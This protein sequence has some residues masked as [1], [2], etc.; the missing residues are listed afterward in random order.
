MGPVTANPD[1]GTEMTKAALTI[2]QGRIGDRN[3][4]A[5]AGSMA[6]GQAF[7]LRTGL[8]PVVIGQPEE[9]LSADW[10]VELDAA[11]PMLQELQT[12]MEAVLRMTDFSICTMPRCAAALAT[13]PMVAKHHPDVCVIWFDSHADLNTPESTISGYL[14]GLALSGPVGLWSSGLGAGIRLDRLVLVGQRDLDPFEKALIAD[15]KI[16]HLSPGPDLPQRLRAAIAG[17]CVYVHLDCDVLDPGI[18][19][20]DY[21]LDGGLSLADLQACCEVIATQ[22]VVGLEIAEFQNAWEKGGAQVS[23]EPLL[24]A[25]MPLIAKLDL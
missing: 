4:L 22:D 5:M 24:N 6:V 14:G 7:A 21:V 10:R 12:R 15:R 20:T 1:T 13:L 2:V 9:P 18:V 25:L 23:P 17:C 8:D 11:Q 19:P 3:D 16:C